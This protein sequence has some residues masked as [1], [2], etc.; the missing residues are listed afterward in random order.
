MSKQDPI[1]KNEF[2]IVET[3]L[4]KIK[5]YIDGNLYIFKGIPYAE[6]PIGDLRFKPPV[7]KKSWSGIL[8]TT[9]FGFNAIQ[10][11]SFLEELMGKIEPESEDC[12]NLNIWTPGIDDK[13]RPVMFWIHGGAFIT[14]SSK[15]PMYNGSALARRGDIVVVS[16]N[17]R[18]G[19]LGYLYVLGKTAN[20]GQLDQIAALKW[21][22]ENIEIF[23]GNPQNV[24]IFGE[25][26]GGMAVTTLPAMPSAQGLFHKIIAQSAPAL[27]PSNSEKFSKSFLRKFKIKG[28]NLEDLR[29]ISPDTLMD[30]Q[31]QLYAKD[32]TNAL[33]LR[34]V[35]DGETLPIHPIEAFKNGKAKNI[36]L[37]IGV[38]LEEFKLFLLAPNYMN[39]K[40]SDYENMLIGYLGTL[41]ID[42][43]KSMKILEIYKEEDENYNLRDI[44]SRVI[45]DV[46]FRMYAVRLCEAQHIHQKNV[47]NYIFTWKSPMLNGLLGACHALELPFVF[48][49]YNLREMK[50]LAGKGPDVKNLSD[51]MIDAW[52]SFARTGNPNHKGIPEWSPYDLEKR[53]TMIFGKET[54]VV[55]DPF[56]KQR[57]V[58]GNK[59]NI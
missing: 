44:F 31:N 46:I 32:P 40:D 23:G 6:P 47:Y 5:G 30:I 42:K 3:K 16:I 12:L 26:A 29:K 14:G 13:K 22:K 41:G 51:K 25:S 57:E 2:E 35:V 15:Q 54:S 27:E 11:Y 21:V 1:E 48:Q 50:R 34:P 45:T 39:T 36:D 58:W 7:N 56:Q 8:D 43:E 52:I 55:E 24:T 37:M 19:C 20:V 18:L 53:T 17:Y 49:T 4:G 10:G 59:F 28:G 33:A 38:N 9:E